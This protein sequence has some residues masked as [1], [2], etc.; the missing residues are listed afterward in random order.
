M[1]TTTRPGTRGARPI[2]RSV[3][4][5]RDPAERQTDK[6]QVTLQ[7]TSQTA[8]LRTA[9]D[10]ISQCFGHCLRQGGAHVEAEHL[11][12]MLDAWD[13]LN[14]SASLVARDSGYADGLKSV[15][16]KAVKVCEES[17]EEF[18]EDQ[19]MTA[20]ADVCREAYEHLTA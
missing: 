5:R 19:M 14:A 11:T 7:Q 10:T 12:C 1:P 17:C 9:M 18:A 13:L 15:C 2:D 16:A 8:I 6:P 3:R 4:S 20:C